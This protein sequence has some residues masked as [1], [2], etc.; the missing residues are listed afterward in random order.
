VAI[1][2]HHFFTPRAVAEEHERLVSEIAELVLDGGGAEFRE[3]DKVPW[4]PLG[5]GFVSC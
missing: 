5:Q 1:P 2:P 3:F 4:R